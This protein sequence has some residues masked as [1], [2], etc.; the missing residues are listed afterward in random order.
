[1]EFTDG[2]FHSVFD[3][4]AKEY[5]EIE[6]DHCIVD[7]GSAKLADSPEIFDVIVH[8]I[9]MA[10]CSPMSRPRLQARL[11]RRVREYR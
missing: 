2:L 4:V 9:S 1:M 3:E 7:I 5:P 10:T 8:A 6:S 11:A